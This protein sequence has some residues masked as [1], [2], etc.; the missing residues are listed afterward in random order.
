M[1]K[2]INILLVGIL[3]GVLFVPM[4][5]QYVPVTL[6]LPP[7]AGENEVVV[8]PRL[9]D[10]TFFS[11]SYQDSLSVHAEKK[12]GLRNL[13]IRVEAQLL[14]SVF[15]EGQ[16]PVSPGVYPYLFTE[17]YLEKWS[18]LHPE[19]EKVLNERFNQLD[20]LNQWLAARNKKLLLVL[21]PGK[22]TF[23]QEYITGYYKRKKQATNDYS[24]V[25]T[26]MEAS[27]IPFIDFQSYF[28]KLK[29]TCQHPIFPKQG[30]HWTTYAASL[31]YDSISRRIEQL[32]NK[33]ME[34]I[35]WTGGIA[36]TNEENGEN[37]IYCIMNLFTPAAPD[38]FY[39][40][41]FH[42]Q[43]D[44]VGLYRPRVLL[45]AD[46]YV[47]PILKSYVNYNL[48]PESKFWWHNGTEWALCGPYLSPKP[49]SSLNIHDEVLK[50]DIVIFMWA[51]LNYANYDE[52]FYHYILEAE[53]RHQ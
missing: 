19:S 37:D 52:G 26:Q 29:D 25:K 23:Q 49:I 32:L 43:S 11:G 44:T 28:L 33:K 47:W 13:C 3:T 22:A 35:T 38:T 10:S 42:K 46:S 5:F 20:S 6:N 40:P 9:Q 4:A 18:G 24:R 15:G 7:L 31:G 14:Y 39:L 50:Y 27:N 1:R 51:E 2:W 45:I 30:E 48:S 8:M 36:T 17:G 34:Q 21:A 53:R 12:N 16:L 41:W